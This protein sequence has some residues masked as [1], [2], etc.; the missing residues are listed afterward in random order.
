MAWVQDWLPGGVT[1]PLEGGLCNH[2]FLL[3]GKLVWRKGPGRRDFDSSLEQPELSA[4]TMGMSR[5]SGVPTEQVT[6]RDEWKSLGLC[7]GQN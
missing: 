6:F 4:R 1:E 7:L 2:S 3:N 5:A